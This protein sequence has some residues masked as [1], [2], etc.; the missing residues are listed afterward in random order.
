MEKELA[1]YA[2]EYASKLGAN[3]AEARL[4]KSE[5][6]SFLLKNGTPEISGFNEISGLG[7][8]LIVEG[9][10]SFV[11]T[12]Q[13][14]K[15]RI[16]TLVDKSFKAAKVV[17]KI[18]E[19]INL[20]EDTPKQAT[21]E[22]K[23]KIKIEDVAPSEKVG[24][25]IEADKAAVATGIK[26][27]G[28]YLTLADV[29]TTE[30]LVNS[31]GTKTLAK[32]PK[33]SFL[34]FITVQHGTKSMQRY[35]QYGNSGGFEFVKEWDLVKVVT[36]EIKICDFMLKKGKL[37]KPMKA[38]LVVAP[39]V[40]GIMVHESVGHPYEADRILGREGAQAGES[41]VSPDMIGMQIGSS[42]VTVVDDPTIPF[43]Y[44]HY[45]YD[46]EGVKARRKYLMKEGKITEFLHNR[47]TAHKM[48]LTSNGSSRSVDY[49]KESIVR[50]S[51]TVLLPG[52]YTEE[53][54]IEGVKDGIFMKN[55]MEW[56]IDDKRI[57]QKYVGA[58]A[59]LIKNGKLEEPVSNA[60]IEIS[61]YN[62]YKAVDAVANNTEYHSGNCGKGEP[63]QAIPVW[64]GGPSMR[65][66][67]LRVK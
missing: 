21:Y 22:V 56:N 47:Q 44:G 25:L 8:R 31:E 62:L 54:L 24:L 57:H 9:G 39:Q 32:I 55:F 14:H 12:N 30:Y 1:E 28:R 29:T 64:F 63:M 48:G 51:N 27:A 42:A 36:D 66:R 23:Q 35:W 11:S 60:T 46:N 3:Y 58:E 53:E 16:K 5:G 37:V 33:V 43:S 10:L 45:L 6:T 49:D 2:V 50:M 18:K 4:Q 38:D 20:A 61:T 17:S 65:L 13:L 19:Q 52:K 67:N 26:T 7:I 34:Y 15:P 41:F 40:V 59:Y